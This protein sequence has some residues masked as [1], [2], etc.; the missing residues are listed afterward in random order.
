MSGQRDVLAAFRGVRK[1]FDGETLVV[2]DLDLDIHRGEFLTL[3][4][5]SGSGKTTTLMMLAGFE[6]PTAGE[7]TLEGRS[8]AHL[9]PHRRDIGM[10]FQNYA[11]FPHMSVAENVAFP[12]SVRG[13]SRDDMQARVKRALDM[14]RLDGFEGR[15]PNQLSGGQQQRVA[16]AR[17][18]VF[19]PTLVL[20]DEPL[21]ALDKQLRE[22]MQL[23]IRHLHERLEVTVVYVTHDQAEALTMSDR[24]AVFHRGLV[25]QLDTPTALYE[26]PRN[27]FVARFIGE[28]NRLPGTLERVDGET[29]TVRLA[30]GAQIAARA[31]DVGATGSPVTVSLRPERIAIAAN[32]AVG[33]AGG[34][35][36]PGRLQELIYLGDHVRALIEL[37]G[38]ERCMVK[39]ATEEAGALGPGAVVEAVWAPQDGL[40]FAPETDAPA[41]RL[42]AQ[43][44]G[45]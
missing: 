43:P 23:E 40:A 12:L 26:R 13:L 17:A 11:L 35:R 30:G 24:I 16:L 34:N 42:A 2:R 15:R 38:G 8:L 31:A 5:P 21:G 18:L 33:G 37:T 6:T 10:V 14:V 22:E 9:P 1:T 39:L 45:D 41:P 19:E 3:L 44:A 25:Q 4:G 20:M 27:A 28:N 7:I 32:G 29:C 36:V